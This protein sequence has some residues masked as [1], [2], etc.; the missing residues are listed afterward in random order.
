MVTGSTVFDAIGLEG[1]P[2][3]ADEEKLRQRSE[4]FGQ[5]PEIPGENARWLYKKLSRQPLA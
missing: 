4:K 5:G 2:G 3:N 1:Q